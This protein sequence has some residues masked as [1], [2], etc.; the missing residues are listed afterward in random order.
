MKSVIVTGAGG[1]MGKSICRRLS[2]GGYRVFGIDIGDYD[3]ECCERYSCDITDAEAVTDTIKAIAEKAGQIFAVVHAAGIYRLNSL[4]EMSEDEFTGIFNVNLFG[5]YRVN[6]AVMPYLTKGSRI[7]IVTSELAPLDPLPFT[8]IY[9]ITKSALEKYADSLRMELNLL[10]ISVSV[11][12]P[13]ATRTPLLGDSTDALE[14]FNES[15]V[16]YK[17]NAARFK[18]VV[19]SVESKSVSADKIGALAYR[20]LGARCPRLLYNVNRNPLLILL[21]ILPKRMQLLVIKMIL[22]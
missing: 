10:G 16:L 14:K 11:I 20:A 2:D 18:T 9:G 19:D 15:T 5:V 17:Y 13:G 7:V 21:S 22:K 1:G 12:R 4:V 6:K 3:H 8:G